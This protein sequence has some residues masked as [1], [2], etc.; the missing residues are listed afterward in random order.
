MSRTEKE[1][2]SCW[3]KVYL[4][5]AGPG[6]PG[7]MTL[8]GKGLLECADVVIYDALVSQAILDMINPQAEKINAGKR[9]GRHS[10]LQEETTHLLIEKAQEHA[11][12]VRL[13]GGDPFIFGRGGEE[14][15]DLV[16]A[17]VSVEVVPGITS[18]I[19]ASAYAGIPLTHR[20]YSSSVTFVTGHE[21]AGKYKP[22]V[23]WQA[24][25]HG[26]ETIVIYM[27]I[28]NLPYIVEQFSQAGLDSATPIALVRWGTR[29]EQEE[30]IGTLATIIEQVAETGFSAPAIAVIGSVV[31]MHSILPK[32][33]PV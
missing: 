13:K 32:C 21:S 33:R 15:A 31:N 25:A 19:A 9:M 18:G 7:L 6:D 1:A 4:L 5:G 10:L 16:Q 11:I 24:I 8:K 27:G 26:S 2:Q 17:G 14:M 20:L 12:V 28:H 30:L 23:N 29:P 22:K 3:G